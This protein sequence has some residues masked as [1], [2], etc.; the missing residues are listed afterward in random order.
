M[1]VRS[2]YAR[3]ARLM[4]GAIGI[5]L[6]LTASGSDAADG[7]PLGPRPRPSS[8]E[9][10]RLVPIR[11]Q[12]ATS[13]P[14]DWG[15]VPS[16]DPITGRI[17]LSF[18][19]VPGTT[20][21]VQFSE[22]LTAAWQDLQSMTADVGQFAAVMSDSDA[23]TRPQRFYR[24][25]VTAL[26]PTPTPTPTVVPTP[27]PTF[28]ST[29]TPTP[30]P[31]GPTP[32]PTPTAIFIPP[33][34]VLTPTPTLG[35]L[36][37]NAP[38][39][40]S[41]GNNKVV[42]VNE[43]VNLVGTATDDGKPVGGQ[44]T[45]YWTILGG[46]T[47]PSPANPSQLSTTVTF[48]Q[49][50]T[51]LAR[52]AVSDSELSALSEIT[53][54]VVA[55][56]D[57]IPPSARSTRG[58]EFWIAFPGV[59]YNIIPTP[60][61]ADRPA[62]SGSKSPSSYQPNYVVPVDYPPKLYLIIAAEEGA[63][64]TVQV[65]GM[66]SLQSF[67]IA[68]GGTTRVNV[69]SLAMIYQNDY[70]E[71]KGVFVTSDR[72]VTIF[73]VGR[74]DVLFGP[75]GWV[76]P[77]AGK[78]P[79]D[80]LAAW[81]VY[82]TPSLG[83]AYRV[84]A[85]GTFLGSGFT[86]V[87]T[88]DNTTVT[89]DLVVSYDRRTAGVPYQL[90][91]QRGQTYQFRTGSPTYGEETGSLITADKPIAVIGGNDYRP[92]Y[93][94][95]GLFIFDFANSF[96][97][98]LPPIGS[99]GTEFVASRWDPNFATKPYEV[100]IVAGSEAAT[101]FVNGSDAGLA[102]DWSPLVLSL[103]GTNRIL[104]D[105]PVQVFATMK[106]W[107]Y[108][109][110]P[111][112]WVD[113]T[114]TMLPPSNAGSRSYLVTP[115]ADEHTSTLATVAIPDAG[116]ASLR[117]NG[118][119]VAS[120]LFI[121]VPNSDLY[122]AQIPIGAGANLLTADQP[123]RAI[124]SGS[125]PVKNGRLFGLDLA[126]KFIG[127]F[128]TPA[129]LEFGDLEADS[130][131]ALVNDPQQVAPGQTATLT[132]R[133]LNARGSPLGG[134]RV[135]F[136]TSGA[137]SI[138]GS[139]YTDFL[140]YARYAYVGSSA[141]VDLVLATAGSHLA[142]GQVTWSFGGPGPTPTPLPLTPTPLPT[143]L[144]VPT[145]TPTPTAT[146]IPTPTPTLRPGTPTRTPSPTPTGPT[147]TRTPT[148]TVTP[149][150][151]NTQ[152]VNVSLGGAGSSYTIPLG[153]SIGAA[154]YADRPTL[155]SDFY[156]QIDGAR[157]PDYIS[158]NSYPETYFYGRAIH[159][160]PPA[161]GDY[162]VSVVAKPV[163]GV[164]VNLPGSITFHVVAPVVDPTLPPVP[165]YEADGIGP[166]EVS[167]TWPYGLPGQGI[168]S[169]TI[170]RRE[171]I[172]GEARPAAQTGWRT[173]GTFDFRNAQGWT[174]PGLFT[175]DGGL[176]PSTNYVYRFAYLTPSGTISSTSAE[177]PARTKAPL[178]RYAVVDL[179][180][181]IGRVAQARAGGRKAPPTTAKPRLNAAGVVLGD[182]RT[183]AVNNQGHAVVEQIL[184]GKYSYWLWNPQSG[185][186]EIPGGSAGRGGFIAT[187]LDENDRVAGRWDT[188]E[189]NAGDGSIR[190]HAAYWVPGIPCRPI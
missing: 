44:L 50:G 127:S 41:A 138:T 74:R 165:N 158:P 79:E 7:T 157:I 110:N 21:Q 85:P 92:F 46:A 42:G 176:K 190:Y 22:D 38:P 150:S 94:I 132:A 169:V 114:M 166:T 53:I 135:Y 12:T 31:G 115:L 96:A 28:T 125:S 88:D 14:A 120:N 33:V 121:Q 17:D 128:A 160:F 189:R 179:T 3:L 141:G 161:V 175:K 25:T 51:Y 145:V 174:G 67:S 171:V 146:R 52:L 26:P 134:I 62:Q 100:T 66:S 116:R 133:V 117:L 123:F 61:F 16:R 4:C 24:V 15:V 149:V 103:T 154:A 10:T 119:V 187:G 68:P 39:V 140:G 155:L 23:G 54:T 148:P 20:Y 167:L 27:T 97:S 76:T 91:L 75:L 59:G 180:A 177:I 47:P 124:L 151:I 122:V 30:T 108:A 11:A 188:G 2:L 35:P 77:P 1:R 126:D 34:G 112:L 118:S 93:D 129:G 173:I 153:Q 156:L 45:T 131:I 19:T 36:A 102:F 78:G 37:P 142:Q 43:T 159:W 130:S 58:T 170:E 90:V 87:A 13:T 104:S 49:P 9:L 48:T 143:R 99:G 82:P 183:I 65:P 32:T 18:P 113:D 70:V 144:P 147:P 64:G 106:D 98:Q 186:V 60:T 56:A 111:D 101:I 139:A 55:G 73:A 105:K 83:V 63:T 178:P 6:L 137:N 86:V 164:A 57:S 80:I 8:P 182:G 29:P 72:P 89:I 168:S 162:V 109:S 163:P 185:A 181:Q 107:A 5:A 184:N 71:N 152:F 172:E 40:V 69:P 136:A 81:L 95:I 84:V